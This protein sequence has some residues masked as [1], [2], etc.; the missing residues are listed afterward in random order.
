MGVSG[1]QTERR[2]EYWGAGN[3]LYLDLGSIVVTQVYVCVK[4]HQDVCP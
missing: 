4:I 3:V 1:V 2:R